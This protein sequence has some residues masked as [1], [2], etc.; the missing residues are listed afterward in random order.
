MKGIFRFVPLLVLVGSSL[1][2]TFLLGQDSGEAIPSDEIEELNTKPRIR[3]LARVTNPAVPLA[4]P[5]KGHGGHGHH[6]SDRNDHIAV[7]ADVTEGVR[8]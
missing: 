3:Y 4:P 7:D 8:A 6:S 2:Q 5:E 1:L